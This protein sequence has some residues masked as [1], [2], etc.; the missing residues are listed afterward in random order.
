VKK[1][2]QYGTNGGA[3]ATCWLH[4]HAL[5]VVVDECLEA[6]LEIAAHERLH[7]K[8]SSA[9][10]HRLAALLAQ[11]VRPSTTLPGLPLMTLCEVTADSQL[12]LSLKV[13]P[14]LQRVRSGQVRSGQ[15]RSG[16][17]R[18]GQVRSGQVRSGQVRSG[19]VRSGQ[20]RSGQVRS[21]Q[22]SAQ[23]MAWRS[24]GIGQSQTRSAPRTRRAC[25]SSASRRSAARRRRRRGSPGGRPAAS[26]TGAG[27]CSTSP[28]AGAAHCMSVV[29][30]AQERHSARQPVL[31]LGT[32][33]GPVGYA[34]LGNQEAVKTSA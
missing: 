6:G 12:G 15:V 22:V 30:H 18:S 13:Y 25:R 14:P 8:G 2:P 16:Q 26:S 23:L 29:S 19:Q 20:V 4:R 1:D 28:P 24:T 32:V 34:S 17:V 9:R 27:P 10:H 11:G 7:S 5:L 33:F 21:G 3:A 31:D